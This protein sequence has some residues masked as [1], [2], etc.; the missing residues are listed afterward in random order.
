MK[1]LQVPIEEK[2]AE[3]LAALA[4][5]ERTTKAEL[6]RRLIVERLQKDA[7]IPDPLDEIVGGVDIE[8]ADI[9]RV[10]YGR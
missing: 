7:L 4:T 8:P 6:V 1:R 10:V 5:R 9:D 3:A 2:F